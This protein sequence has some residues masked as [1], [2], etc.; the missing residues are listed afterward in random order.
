MGFGLKKN[1]EGGQVFRGPFLAIVAILPETLVAALVPAGAGRTRTG[2]ASA[3][4]TGSAVLRRSLGVASS[5]IGRSA[6]PT[7]GA[8]PAAVVATATAIPRR[9]GFTLIVLIGIMLQGF[10][11]PLGQ[12]LQFG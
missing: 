3:F 12:K 4:G 6:G 7:G 9:S 8:A 11:R 10:F 5:R 2:A 1:F